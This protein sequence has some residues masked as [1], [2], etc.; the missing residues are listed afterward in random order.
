VVSECWYWAKIGLSRLVEHCVE[1]GRSGRQPQAQCLLATGQLVRDPQVSAVLPPPNG[2]GKTTT[3]NC[4]TGVLPIDSGDARFAPS[5]HASHPPCA[6][7]PALVCLLQPSTVPAAALPRAAGDSSR[8]FI[9]Q[10]LHILS[11]A[12]RFCHSKRVYLLCCTG[13]ATWCPMRYLLQHVVLFCNMSSN[14][15]YGESIND[16]QGMINIRGMMGVCPQFD[17]LWDKLTA[18]EHMEVPPYKVVVLTSSSTPECGKVPSSAS[19]VAAL[20]RNQ[21]S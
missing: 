21:G 17:M 15:V 14:R 6:H 9:H 20:R 10:G 13:I 12:S 5:C 7:P 3:I 19:M 4:L 11:S 8:W 1:Y 2:A 16:H 18:D